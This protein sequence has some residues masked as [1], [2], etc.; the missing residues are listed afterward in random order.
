MAGTRKVYVR[1][2]AQLTFHLPFIYLAWTSRGPL[3]CSHRR[4]RGLA[5]VA[6]LVYLVVAVAPASPPILVLR[7]AGPKGQGTAM[8]VIAVYMADRWSF[9]LSGRKRRT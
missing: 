5:G 7:S 2:E 8:P 9:Q 3:A 4:H 1:H 6:G